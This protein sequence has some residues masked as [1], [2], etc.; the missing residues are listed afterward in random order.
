MIKLLQF[1][2]MYDRDMMPMA[3]AQEVGFIELSDEAIALHIKHGSMM[4][5]LHSTMHLYPINGVAHK[6]GINETPWSYRKAVWSEVIVGVDPDRAKK[7]AIT[8]WARNYWEAFHP[9]GAGGAYVNFMMEGEGEDRIR[10]TYQDNYERLVQLKTKYDP[11]NFFR[12][13]QNVPPEGST[14]NAA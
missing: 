14:R 6:T 11:G 13:N 10:A 2:T 5:T 3:N 4:P 12:G 9:Y 8:A 7:E 1:K